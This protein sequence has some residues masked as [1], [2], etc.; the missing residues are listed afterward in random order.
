MTFLE[1]EML[2]LLF[3]SA[4]K[5]PFKLLALCLVLYI[6]TTSF[7]VAGIVMLAVAH[8]AKTE[9]DKRRRAAQAPEVAERPAGSD[10]AQQ[11]H[12]AAKVPAANDATESTPKRQYAK[13][14]VVIPIK[15]GTK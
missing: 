12:R 4:F 14:A 5:S 6:A 13:S 3:K 10:A 8:W 7:F 15:T 11:L 2:T 9:F 1:R